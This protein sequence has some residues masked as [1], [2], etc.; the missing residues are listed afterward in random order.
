MSSTTTQTA[1]MRPISFA[2]MIGVLMRPGRRGSYRTTCSARAQGFAGRRSSFG[3]SANIVT[4]PVEWWNR[5]HNRH[6]I[7]AMKGL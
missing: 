6:F 4:P 2:S 7:E 3:R 1:V 5:A